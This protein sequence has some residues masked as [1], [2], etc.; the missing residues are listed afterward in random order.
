MRVIFCGSGGF[1]VPSLRAIFGSRHE[2]AGII[3]QPARPAGR[4][5]KLRATPVAVAAQEAG[6]AVIECPDINADEGIATVG[7]LGGEVIAVADYGQLIRKAVRRIP[8]R[9]AFNLHGSLLPEL[10]GAAPVNWA[11]I[12]GC[13]RTGVTTFALVGKM[14]AGDIYLQQATEICPQETAEELK[15]RLAEIGAGL[16]IQTLDLLESGQAVGRKQDESLATLAPIL[17]KSDGLVDW[18]ADSRTIAN[19][20]HG[21]W[22]WPGGQATFVKTGGKSVPVVLARA[23]AVE[24]QAASEGGIVQGDG[25]ISCG[26]G[27]LRILEIQPAGKRLMAWR[28]FV[29]GYRVV[30]GDRFI[31]AGA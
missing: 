17:Q 2:L 22:P 9:G 18:A 15:A 10:R 27:R 21:T 7:A 24:G 11:I 3:T 23:E 28:D 13:R 14:D 20:I 5:G 4:G 12:R 19:R 6:R 26:T 16:M 8:P 1:A 29:N 30:A 25:S 31:S